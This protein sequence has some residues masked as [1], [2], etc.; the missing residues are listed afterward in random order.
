MKHKSIHYN[1][2]KVKNR[3]KTKIKHKPGLWYG[4][5]PARAFVSMGYDNPTSALQEVMDN[6]NAYNDSHMGVGIEVQSLTGG[7]VYD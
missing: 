2:N 7:V 6:N 1:N 3:N 5:W 4:E